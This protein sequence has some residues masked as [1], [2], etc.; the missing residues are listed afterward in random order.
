MKMF[1][2]HTLHKQIGDMPKS[3]TLEHLRQVERYFLKEVKKLPLEQ[4]YDVNKKGSEHA[5]DKLHKGTWGKLNYDVIHFTNV[6][7]LIHH[8]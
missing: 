5:S 8:L 6:I 2:K 4:D 1:N 3:N 7:F